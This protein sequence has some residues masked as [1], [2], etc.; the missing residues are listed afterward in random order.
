[1]STSDTLEQVADDVIAGIDA[2]A[3]QASTGLGRPLGND[4]RGYSLA[5]ALVISGAITSA[6][7]HPENSITVDGHDYPTVTALSRQ[8][9][10]V[11]RHYVD[12]VNKHAA[13]RIHLLTR[14]S[15]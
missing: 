3:A 13:R 6:A 15:A 14:G 4:K 2:V 10:S 1:M 11:R 5:E 12:R 7:L 8:C 9:N